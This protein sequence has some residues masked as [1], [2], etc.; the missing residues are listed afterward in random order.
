M[1]TV[2]PS[3]FLQPKHSLR[4]L[5]MQIY[6]QHYILLEFL[7]EIIIGTFKNITHNIR[8]HTNKI[9]GDKRRAVIQKYTIDSG[10]ESH[11][12]KFICF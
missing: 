7:Y 2:K 4:F 12:Q 8:K 9:R 6:R 5:I 11:C 1:R 10:E 3:G